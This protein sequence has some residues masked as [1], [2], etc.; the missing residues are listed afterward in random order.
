MVKLSLRPKCDTFALCISCNRAIHR[1]TSDNLFISLRWQIVMYT[2]AQIWLEPHVLFN[3][4]FC[5]PVIQF[6]RKTGRIGQF[7][8]L[9]ILTSIEHNRIFVGD[10][11]L[12]KQG[13]RTLYTLQAIYKI[14]FL[15]IV[16]GRGKTPEK[17]FCF[18][19]NCKLLVIPNVLYFLNNNKS[20]IVM[21]LH[22]SSNPRG[23]CTYNCV[24]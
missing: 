8:L 10:P 23:R 5:V 15:Y 13:L 19:Q 20:T 18:L 4:G 2:A 17:S 16:M 7:Q 1:Q 9:C 24:P 6:Q 11:Y 22:A 14:W 21:D 12:P 3:Y